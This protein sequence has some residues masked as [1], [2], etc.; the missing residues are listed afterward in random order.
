MNAEDSTFIVI[1]LVYGVIL[2]LFLISALLCV[3]ANWR[4]FRRAGYKGWYSLVP[5]YAGFTKQKIAFGD[6][7][8]WFY[9]IGWVLAA[10]YY[11]TRFAFARAFGGSK[12]FAVLSLFFPGI[13]SLV[14]AFSASYQ[15]TDYHPVSHVLN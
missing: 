6:E 4:L 2:F 14:L 13:T 7:N 15:E 11:Y 8:K 9:F 10:Y 3:I 12:G 5:I 1:A